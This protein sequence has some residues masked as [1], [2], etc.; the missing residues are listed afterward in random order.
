MRWFGRTRAS[1]RRRGCDPRRAGTCLSVCLL[2][3]LSCQ[4]LFP[5]SSSE[6][7]HNTC[8]LSEWMNDASVGFLPMVS[9]GYVQ[10]MELLCEYGHQA[11]PFIWTCEWWQLG[12]DKVRTSSKEYTFMSSSKS[13]L[14]SF[15]S[16]SAVWLPSSAF[17]FPPLVIASAV[18]EYITALYRVGHCEWYTFLVL[19][20]E[21]KSLHLEIEMFIKNKKAEEKYK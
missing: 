19:H 11:H 2:L 20:L 21:S 1:S 16:S 18:R 12:E 5:E 13:F 9:F 6:K 4:S 8:L 7:A 3:R 10:G 15:H 14:A 17:A